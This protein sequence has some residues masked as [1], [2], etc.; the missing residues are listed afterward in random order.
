MYGQSPYQSTNLMNVASS[1]GESVKK[2]FFLV[3]ATQWMSGGSATTGITVQITTA[4]TA[5]ATYVTQFASG[6][7]TKAYLS[8]ASQYAAQPM[9]KV[10][11][12]ENMLQNR[13]IKGVFVT[14]S[15]QTHTRVLAELT[16]Y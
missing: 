1:L 11:I 9:V 2:F 12:F 13:F 15:T 4:L 5:A 16:T 8:V 14:S 7:I 10:P 6:K 3:N